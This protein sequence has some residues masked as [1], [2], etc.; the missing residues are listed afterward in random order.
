MAELA[1]QHI[2]AGSPLVINK[3]N[4]SYIAYAEEIVLR[5][6]YDTDQAGKSII[7]FIEENKGSGS[8]GGGDYTLPAAT[9]KTLGGVR[10]GTEPMSLENNKTVPVTNI[11]GSLGIALTD[12]FEGGS[13]LALKSATN[14]V[15]GGVKVGTDNDFENNAPFGIPLNITNSGYINFDLNELIRNDYFNSIIGLQLFDKEKYESGIG[16][17]LGTDSSKKFLVKEEHLDLWYSSKDASK[18]IG[19]ESKIDE[20][21]GYQKDL[22]GSVYWGLDYIY[23]IGG[24]EVRPGPRVIYFDDINVNIEMGWPVT[25]VVS[26]YIV[27]D[28]GHNGTSNGLPAPTSSNHSQTLYIINGSGNDYKIYTRHG[29]S[30]INSED[31]N[32]PSW[33]YWKELQGMSILVGADKSSIIC[34]DDLDEIV[35]N[36]MYGGVLR[37]DNFNMDEN[38]ALITGLEMF[39]LIVINNYAISSEMSALVDSLGMYYPKQVIQYKIANPLY[40]TPLPKNIDP[41]TMDPTLYE[42]NVSMRT[43]IYFIDTNSYIWGDW[44]SIGG[45]V[46]IV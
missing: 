13:G 1:K 15:Q 24:N 40:G 3:N 14:T 22:D 25:G 35:D 19:N 6:D 30:S 16:I 43:G 36:G 33:G 12:S 34:T 5:G 32:K 11:N 2:T 20:L 4:G 28:K 7:D 27:L 37:K 31:S 38:T 26:G 29:I 23:I 17:Y 9:T 42:G 39:T 8:G 10:L 18:L 41:D 21:V 45:G 46:T 44:K